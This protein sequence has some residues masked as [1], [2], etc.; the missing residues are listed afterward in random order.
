MT[1]YSAQPRSPNTQAIWRD[2][3]TIK[4]WDGSNWN[5]MGGGISDFSVDVVFTPVDYNTVSWG[6]GVI[7]ISSSAGTA[8]FAISS[9]SFDLTTT[10][11]FYW[12]E[13]IPTAIQTTTDAAIAIQ[14]GGLLV[15]T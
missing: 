4:I 2:G 12:Q 7:N 14:N 3:A 9:G 5:V 10:T 6:S 15:A 13:D 11:Y 8:S 1:I